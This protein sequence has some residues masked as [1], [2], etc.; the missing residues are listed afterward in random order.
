MS[1]LRPQ[2]GSPAGRGAGWEA[3]LGGG[4]RATPALGTWSLRSGRAGRAGCHGRAALG[5][6]TTMG[7]LLHRATSQGEPLL[8]TPRRRGHGRENSYDGV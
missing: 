5:C 4:G 1:G 2:S 3:R 7:K 8:A 6:R